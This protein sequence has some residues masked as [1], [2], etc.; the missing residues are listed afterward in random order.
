MLDGSPP[1][2]HNTNTLYHKN[3]VGLLL[4]VCFGFSVFSLHCPGKTIL[5]KGTEAAS[6]HL[7]QILFTNR[8]G[9]TSQG[10]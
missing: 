5:R 1:L 4:D 2:T 9:D 6:R 3:V 8:L 7:G 10:I